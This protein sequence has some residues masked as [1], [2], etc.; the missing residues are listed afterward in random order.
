MHVFHLS[1]RGRD[2]AP[3][4]STRPWASL[5]G[6]R[7]NLRR[8]RAAK[9][10]SGPVTVQVG[11]GHY[12]QRETVAFTHADS[13][14]R[15][16]AAPGAKPV[17]DGGERLSGWKVGE[18]NGRTEWTLDLPD[19][20]A[21]KRFFRSLFVNGRRAPRARFPKFSPDLKGGQNVLRVGEML[22][23]EKT[24][25]GDGR[26]TFKPR[27]GD[28][29]D[30]W[31]SLPE[32]EFV[33]LHYWIEERLP[34]PALN[35]RTGWVSFARRS[36]F[37]FY[38]AHEN[39][40][41]ERDHARYYI[42]N[43]FEA[44]TEPGEWYLSRETGRI[45]YLPRPG[46]TPANTEIRAPRLHSFVRAIGSVFGESGD[47]MDVHGTKQVS[48]LEFA[49]LTFRHG[50]WYSPLAEKH[51]P[52]HDS[53]EGN[54]L[55]IGGSP[56]AAIAVPGAILFRAAR[57]CA[58]VDC[59]LEHLGVY[60]IEFGPGCR[61]CSAVG[62]EIHD[63]GAGGIRA[64]GA[65]LDGLG[66]RRTG[67][68]RIT[69][70]H[71]HHIGRVFHQGIGV[72]LGNAADCVVAH[73]HIHD[74][75]YT[76][77]SLG[78][79]WG[80]RDTITR[81]NVVENNLI[82]DI[83]AGLL[84]DMGGIYT[85][86]IQPGTILRGNHLHHI[87]SHDYGGWGVY[88]DE[89]TSYVV[90]EHNLVHDTKDASFNIHYGHENIVRNNIF[91]RGKRAMVSVYRIEPGHFS[92]NFHT[93]ILVGPSP[94][95]YR[96]GYKGNIASGALIAN[97][98]CIWSPGGKIPPITNPETHLKEGHPAKFTFAQWQKTGHDECSIIADPKITE[99]RKTW[100]VAPNSPALKLGFK[101]WDWSK[102]GPRPRAQRT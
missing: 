17:F 40:K 85:L 46:E 4:S 95:L 24:G 2:T 69:D 64:G 42:D 15:F 98:N 60:G 32:A 12:E 52:T 68:I 101:P 22:E 38:E 81:N 26:D 73:N 29:S 45:Y 3:G 92:A 9:K 48:A 57:N 25:L 53:L 70:N 19:V 91:A 7:D 78:W 36:A 72:L 47:R 66:E 58:V 63:L 44:L 62:N 59:T 89:G 39:A 30:T 43:L 71:I 51:I 99:G 14:T 6:A 87:W 13:H 86:G 67:D 11:A 61:D 96:G 50:D 37:V 76:G 93:N 80:F 33:V 102:C 94:M 65:D 41:G 8:L 54:D 10:I 77:I 28:V 21:G 31:A 90:V 55:P 35:P 16:A 83:G 82:H 34:K 56:Q 5:A 97:A 20:V 74:T 75:C 79:T 88:L 49:G 1:P 100:R 18:R 84:S 27:P 23:P